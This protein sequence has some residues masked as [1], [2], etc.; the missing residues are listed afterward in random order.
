MT[1]MQDVVFGSTRSQDMTKELLHRLAIGDAMELWVAEA[2]GQIVCAGRLDPVPGTDFAGIW[3][4]ATLK[5]WRGKGIYRAITAAR[6]PISLD[7]WQDV[8][9]Q[10]IYRILTS[11]I[12]TVRFAQGFRHDSVQLASLSSWPMSS[13]G[14]LAGAT[15]QWAVVGSVGIEPTTEGL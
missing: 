15:P 10:R 6:S 3:G 9:I 4:G 12:G 14:P 11:D 7:G 5:D 13:G 1:S 2:E 8:D